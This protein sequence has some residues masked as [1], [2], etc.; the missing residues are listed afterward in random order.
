V[1]IENS[2]FYDIGDSGIRVGHTPASTDTAA[3]IVQGVMAQNNLIQGYSRVFADG[4]GIAEGNGNNN[5]YSYNTIT[6]G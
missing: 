2:S 6:D 5:R 3:T 4:E 1:T